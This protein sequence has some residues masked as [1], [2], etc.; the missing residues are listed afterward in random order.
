MKIY[1]AE[2]NS[3]LTEGKGHSIYYLGET[4]STAERI[5]KGKDVQGYDCKVVEIELGQLSRC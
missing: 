4:R 5:G 1:G 2:S 3:D